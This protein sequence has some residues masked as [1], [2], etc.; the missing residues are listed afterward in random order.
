MVNLGLGGNYSFKEVMKEVR[1][2]M[3]QTFEGRVFL[4]EGT[5]HVKCEGP[6]VLGQASKGKG[7]G[8][9]L[10]TLCC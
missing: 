5:A 2:H 9:L 3:M 1:E 8:C 4:E 6:V 7:R 10:C